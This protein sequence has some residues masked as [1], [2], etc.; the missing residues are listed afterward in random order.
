MF[1]FGYVKTVFNFLQIFVVGEFVF[2][3]KKETGN[4]Q[5]NKI[6]NTKIFFR[7]F[8]ILVL[9]YNFLNKRT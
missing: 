6:N 1:V 7:N 5:D 8:L 4:L 9:V 3:V 2:Q